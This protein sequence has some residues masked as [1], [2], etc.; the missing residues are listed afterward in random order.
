MYIYMYIF[1]LF[2]L[3][4]FLSFS[5]GVEAKRVFLLFSFFLSFYAL[6]KEQER[7]TV[8]VHRLRDFFLLYPSL[9]F[10]SF[11]CVCVSSET[12]FEDDFFLF[13]HYNLFLRGLSPKQPMYNLYSRNNLFFYSSS[14]IR[15][16]RRL[17]SKLKKKKKNSFFL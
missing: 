14:R 7:E 12:F 2:F 13:R 17:L 16:S 15:S 9:I 3:S 10:P 6:L 5:E 1:S 4:F 8:E 11:L